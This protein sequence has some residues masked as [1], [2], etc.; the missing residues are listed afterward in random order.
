MIHTE[1]CN[2]SKKYEDKSILHNIDLKINQGEILAIVGPSGCGKTTFLQIIAGL[3]K[4]DTGRASME[5]I[6]LFCCDDNVFLPPEK[7]EIAMVFQNYALWPHYTVFQNIAYPLKFRS[8]K[9]S[10]YTKIVRETMEMIRLTGKENRYPHEL[11]GGEQQR[12][13]LARALV[14]DP[15]LLLM[16]ESLSNLDAKLKEEMLTEIKKIQKNLGLTI[17]YVTHDQ[18]EAMG[19]S[20]RMAVM[21]RGKIEQIGPVQ[22]IYNHPATEFV[23]G[24]IG[25]NNFIYADPGGWEEKLLQSL[26][27]KRIKRR[28]PGCRKNVFLVRP[29]DIILNRHKGT[30]CGRIKERVFRGNIFEYEL[31]TGNRILKAYA[32]SKDPFEC[33]EKVFFEFRRASVID[34]LEKR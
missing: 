15:K 30:L 2:L 28:K 1:I 23:A 34:D 10:E 27:G 4:A 13:A 29:E 20:H 11:S 18:R 3:A 32:N 9:K 17:I 14:R 26:A 19:V 16:D 24:F 25:V 33:G 21:N 8:A 7:R 5:S 31:M 22:E 12:V 6:T